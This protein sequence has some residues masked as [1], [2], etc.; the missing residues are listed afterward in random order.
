M[1]EDN[2]ESVLLVAPEELS[3][4]DGVDETAAEEVAVEELDRL[5]KDGEMLEG[6]DEELYMTLVSGDSLDKI[7]SPEDRVFAE[8]DSR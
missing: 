4:L 7:S 8:I 6:T 1:T 3:R 5:C 2:L